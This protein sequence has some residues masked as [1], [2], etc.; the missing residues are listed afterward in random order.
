M[1]ILDTN[2][3]ILG[4]KDKNNPSSRFLNLAI[5][6]KQ[7]HIS[8]VS[9][10]EFLAKPKKEERQKFE[11][12]LNISTIL[13]VDETVARQA[14]IYRGKYLKK[15][16]TSLLDYLIAA[17]AKVHNLTLVTNNTSDFP[18]KDIKVMRPR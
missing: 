5:S 7:V 3:L 12:L 18:M 16:R 14:A 15:S 10:A 8:V 13:E 1:Y 17:Q 11:M 6:T 9:V 4:I 2:V